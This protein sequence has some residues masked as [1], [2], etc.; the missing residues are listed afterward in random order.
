MLRKESEAVSEGNGPVRQEEKIGF[1]QPALADEY[2]EIRS[3]SKQQEK[4]LDRITRLLDQLSE[5]LEHEARQPRL[6]M[7]AD[8]PADIK[9]RERTEG[10]ATAVQAMHEDGFSAHRV[11][12]GPNTNSTSFGVKAEPLALSCRDDVVESGNAASESCLPSLE[13]RSSTAAGG[14][15]PTGEASTASETTSNKPLL[16]FYETEEMNPEADSRMEDSWTL[17]PSAS[18]DSSSF[19][20]LFAALCCYGV[21]ESK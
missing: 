17:T 2:L 12:P 16:R 18:Y 11:E 21:V 7:E 8:G 20:R 13:M 5:C 1:G 14:L 6:A 10:A 19:W 15:V 4:R 3:L 9:T